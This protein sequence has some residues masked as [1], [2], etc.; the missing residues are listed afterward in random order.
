MDELTDMS[1]EEIE[2]MYYG[3]ED[4]YDIQQAILDKLKD[5]VD[6]SNT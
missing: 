6:E 2:D 1:Y 5:R 4:W 3:Y